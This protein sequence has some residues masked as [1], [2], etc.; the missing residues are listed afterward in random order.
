MQER[1]EFLRGL[2]KQI[3]MRK[4]KREKALAMEARDDSRRRESDYENHRDQ[5]AERGI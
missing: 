2:E 1:T 4:F 5:L 3:R